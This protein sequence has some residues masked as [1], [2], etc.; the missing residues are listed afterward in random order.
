MDRLSPDKRS[1]NMAAVRGKN[2]SPELTVRRLLHAMGYRF[3]LHAKKLP[4]K[5]DI[6]LAK[7]KICIF[8]HGCFWHQHAGC[9]RATVP[10]THKKFWEDKFRQNIE[11]D[12]KI[13]KELENSGWHI[14]IIW[15][16][17]TKTPTKLCHVLFEDSKIGLAMGT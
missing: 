4:G 2:T 11:R 1:S 3:R 5:P 15:E 7:Y 16:C 13:Q 12:A 6:V 10:G 17:E 9:K 14:I 8:V